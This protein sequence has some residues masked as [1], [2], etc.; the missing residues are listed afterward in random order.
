[1]IVHPI[2]P[3]YDAGSKILILGS[4]PSVRSRE[5][6]FYYGHPRNRF[7]RVISSVF[8]ETAPVSIAGK[9]ELLH[10]RHVALWDVIFSC[11]ITA[12]SDARIRNVTVNDL[13]VILEAADIRAI[14][15]NGSAA[16][17][18]YREYL[19]SKTGRPA[20]PLPSTS[21]ANAV[22][23]LERL[24]GAWKKIDEFV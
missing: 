21:P 14:Y 11:D 6:G 20:V 16:F 10:R 24:I 4:F 7:W 8:G 12:S 5:T 9:K 23:S 3:V 13:S 1:M 18:Y 2:P 17:R 22:W 19:Q 15:S